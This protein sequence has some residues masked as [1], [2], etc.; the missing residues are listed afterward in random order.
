MAVGR[1]GFLR[2]TE[3]PFTIELNLRT[4]T[5]LDTV[6]TQ[7]QAII[8]TPQIQRMSSGEVKCP[9]CDAIFTPRKKETK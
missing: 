4:V 6:C 8:E 2:K 5:S 9:Y 7:C 3:E 1:S